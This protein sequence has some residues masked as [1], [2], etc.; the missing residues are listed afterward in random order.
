MLRW[1]LSSIPYTIYAVS[2]LLFHLIWLVCL[3]KQSLVE[4]KKNVIS[5]LVC[6]AI[7]DLQIKFALYSLSLLGLSNTV[8][9]SEYRFISLAD[10]GEGRGRDVF[11]SGGRGPEYP[12]GALVRIRLFVE[13]V[14]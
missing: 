3:A 7:C 12:N 1:V 8:F 4:N 5:D 2:S 9:R 6:D 10:S 14:T 11:R 13:N